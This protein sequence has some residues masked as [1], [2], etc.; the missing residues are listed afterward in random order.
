LIESGGLSFDLLNLV[1]SGQDFAGLGIDPQF[2]N[3][4]DPTPF[5][6]RQGDGHPPADALAEIQVRFLRVEQV[7][8]LPQQEFVGAAAGDFS[9]DPVC[10]QDLQDPLWGFLGHR[11]QT[12]QPIEHRV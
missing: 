4:P 1:S 9:I 7:A 6:I 3:G 2:T 8:H 12:G 5:R 11:S 10:N